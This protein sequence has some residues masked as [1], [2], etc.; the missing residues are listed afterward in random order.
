[1][2]NLNAVEEKRR[3]KRIDSALSVRYRNLRKN[4]NPTT[5]SLSKNIGEGGVC[6]NSPEF[7][8]LACRMIVEITLPTTPKPVRAISKVAWIRRLPSSDN[9]QI[10]NQFLEITKEDKEQISRFVNQ[11]LKINI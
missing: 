5:E 1:M 4:E 2:E 10:G 8:S 3:F 9:Y 6:F 7:I 11:V